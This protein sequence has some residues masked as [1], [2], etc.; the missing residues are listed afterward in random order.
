M[1]AFDE[2][3]KYGLEGW[4]RDREKRMA[5]EGKWKGRGVGGHL[6]KRCKKQD[7]G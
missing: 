2:R 7:R 5:R 3:M 1:E 4:R 6:P